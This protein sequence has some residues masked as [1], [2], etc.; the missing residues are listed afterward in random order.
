L[1]GEGELGPHAAEAVLEAGLAMAD[2]L[3][4]K[5]VIEKAE[6]VIAKGISDSERRREGG[7]GSYSTIYGSG[8]SYRSGVWRRSETDRFSFGW[9]R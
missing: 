6:R 3:P 1:I 9:F 5:V 2:P 4:A 8:T 7:L